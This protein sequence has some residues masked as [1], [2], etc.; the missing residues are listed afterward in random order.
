MVNK[1]KCVTS[2]APGS[3][4]W[5]VLAGKSK[6]ERRLEGGRERSLPW[7][8][9]LMNI[10]TQEKV[11]ESFPG[12]PTGSRPLRH[13]APP[14]AGTG[15]EPGRPGG[16]EAP[17]TVPRPTAGTR[18]SRCRSGP[19]TYSGPLRLQ[20]RA[21][22]VTA[23]GLERLRSAGFRVQLRGIQRPRCPAPPPWRSRESGTSAPATP[24][25]ELL[26]SQCEECRTPDRRF[27]PGVPRN[28]SPILP[29]LGE[30]G[31]WTASSPTSL[32]GAPGSL[33][34]AC[35]PAWRWLTSC[36]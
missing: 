24:E 5:K 11:F 34:L 30:L 7:T 6:S 2:S 26:A 13:P 31:L 8:R 20:S 33:G 29:R 15:C 1:R 27:R 14:Q 17:A 19:A 21:S 23:S 4:A 9:L 18:A 32:F 25:G 10:Q 28:L 22:L 36:C 35:T 16:G 12:R 3:H